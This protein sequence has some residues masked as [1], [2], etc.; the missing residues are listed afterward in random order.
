MT[1]THPTNT[2]PV[3]TLEPGLTLFRSPGPRSSAIHRVVLATLRES[4]G[5]AYWL[6][7]RNVASTYT[8][9]DLAD[10]HRR[11]RRLRIAR[12]FTA[13]QHH[14]LGRELVERVDGRTGLLVA[15]NVT[16]LYRDDDV[17]RYQR[18]RLLE[19]TVRSLSALAAG[20]EMPVVLTVPEGRDAGP[21]ADHADR[22]LRCER[23][24]QGYRFVGP[25]TETTVY[26]GDGYWQTTIPYWVELL[27]AVSGADD[28]RAYGP[29][30]WPAGPTQAT[31]DGAYRGES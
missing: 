16:A 6:D 20:R 2:Q 8:L 1:A 11:L 22:E 31:L 18:D 21:V 9:Y 7:A 17:P 13:Y 26:W 15:P 27:G 10:S 4:S 14:A 30:M 24:D 3:P 19:S 12:A 29:E 25:D 23:T 28:S 5:L